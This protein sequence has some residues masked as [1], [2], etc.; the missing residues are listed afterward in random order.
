MLTHRLGLLLTP[1]AAATLAAT[2]LSAQGPN[3]APQMRGD[4]PPP[5]AKPFNITKSD[6]GL[7][8]VVDVN[9]KAELIARGFGLNEGPVWVRDGQSGYLIVSGLLDN[10]LYKI[11]A[12]KTVSVFMEKAGYTGN[13]V[14]HA[15]AQT[16]SGRSHVLLIGP[17][18]ASLDS[19]GRLIW[20]D[21]NDRAVMRLEKDG[22]TRTTLSRGSND[23]K[24]FSGPNDIVVAKDDAVYLTDNDF[25]LR[26]AAQNPD[27]QLPNGIWRIKDGKSTM[28]LDAMVLGGI[29][30][31]IT[32]SPDEK[33]LYA[34]A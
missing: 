21:D 2:V 33:Y 29:P 25:G 6:P 23:G 11:A 19:Q 9:P 20:C 32:L 13:D 8:A 31:G 22:T 4:G 18:C 3:P 10:V 16:R 24:R 34:N 30:N 15:G 14:D 27:K 12:D 5:A 28:V 1:I 7:D 26:D 17:S